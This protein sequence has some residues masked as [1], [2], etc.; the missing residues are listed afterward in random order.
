MREKGRKKGREGEER[1][2]RE[3]EGGKKRERERS[4][5]EIQ[6]KEGGREREGGEGGR[7]EKGKKGVHSALSATVGTERLSMTSTW[8][9]NWTTPCN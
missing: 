4:G 9:S 6:G 2:K 5:R 1:E 7:E 3:L 8:L